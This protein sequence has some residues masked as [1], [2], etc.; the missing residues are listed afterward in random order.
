MPWFGP[1]ILILL[2]IN[3][4]AVFAP[5]D[6]VVR[7][8]GLKFP[9]QTVYKPLLL[10]SGGFVLWL[11]FLR[12]CVFTFP[13]RLRTLPALGR[14][15]TLQFALLLT[16]MAGAVYLPSLQVNFQHYD[17]T[18]RHISASL[19]SLA[20]FGRLFVTPQPDGMYRP[21]TFISL[22][23]DY[24]LFGD[25]LWG[26]HFQGI[27]LHMLNAGLVGVLAVRLGMARPAGRLAALVFGV[28]SIHFEAVVWPAARFDLLATTFTCLA[29][30]FFLQFWR[31]EGVRLGHASICL[32]SFTAAVLNKETAYSAVLVIAALV[33][34]HR[35]WKL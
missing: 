33:A 31:A 16:A 28:A 14:L 3:V 12:R 35:L 2:A 15:T 21:L 23:A 4:L 29:L 5:G 19:T 20:A 1:G 7:I 18:H 13:V 8:S 24:R 32:L 11:L 30:I 17:W 25:Q 9:A 34:T 22:W 10:L 26:Y 6:S 27:A